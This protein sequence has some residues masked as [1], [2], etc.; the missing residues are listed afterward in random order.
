MVILVLTAEG[1]HLRDQTSS[2]VERDY[3]MSGIK[4]ASIV[5]VIVVP[6][7]SHTA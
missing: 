1:Q 4:A 3:R 7:G 6:K 2:N 5:L